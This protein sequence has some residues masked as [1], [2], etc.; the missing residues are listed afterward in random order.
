MEK[1]GRSKKIVGWHRGNTGTQ[2]CLKCLPKKPKDGYPIIFGCSDWNYGSV[3]V[4]HDCNIEI[5]TIN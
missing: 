1:Q 5:T 3:P 4:C 2:H